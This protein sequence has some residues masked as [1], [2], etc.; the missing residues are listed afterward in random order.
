MKTEQNEKATK[1]TALRTKH[2]NLT[3]TLKTKLTNKLDLK[4]T[5]LYQK[6]TET[7]INSN[8]TGEDSKVNKLRTQ[9]TS[10]TEIF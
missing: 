9:T 6:Q 3:R 10:M 4:T 5:L 7:S 2:N 8:V 1:N